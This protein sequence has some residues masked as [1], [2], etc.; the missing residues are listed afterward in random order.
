MLKNVPPCPHHLLSK[1]EQNRTYFQK[2]ENVVKLFNI[3]AVW[4]MLGLGGGG[5]SWERK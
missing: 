1:Q 5:G 2:Y 4:I 3:T